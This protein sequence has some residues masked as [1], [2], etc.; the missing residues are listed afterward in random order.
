MIQ[1]GV[2][3]LFSVINFNKIFIQWLKILPETHV[4]MFLKA[5]KYLSGN[6][7]FHI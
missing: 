4:K 6:N 7:P 5:K 1:H 2:G 3:L